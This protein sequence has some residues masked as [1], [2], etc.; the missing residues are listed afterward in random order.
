MIKVISGLPN[1]VLGFEV[2]GS[3]TSNDYETVIIPAVETAAAKSQKLRM[4]Y[5]V[6]PEF[7]KFELG[8]MWDD[9][10]VGL[11]HRTLWEKIAVVTDVG[12]ITSGIKLFGFA[13][14]GQVRIFK[15][16]EKSEATDWLAN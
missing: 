11:Q 10:K 4:L 6:T 12:W 9:A 3:V 7:E 16:S 13:V 8:A 5:H 15:N 2:S 14:P 1:K